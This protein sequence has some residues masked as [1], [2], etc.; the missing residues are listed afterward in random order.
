MTQTRKKGILLAII[1]MLIIVI[2]FS[3]FLFKTSDAQAET[4]EDSQLSYFEA[5][6]MLEINEENL[7]DKSP[8]IG[9]FF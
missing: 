9:D 3:S 2:L 7:F 6:S 1:C 4:Q 8:S 5:P